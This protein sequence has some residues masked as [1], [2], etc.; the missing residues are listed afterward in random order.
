[1]RSRIFS[2]AIFTLAAA[3]GIA[4]TP[5]IVSAVWPVSGRAV[6]DDPAAQQ[7]P[8]ITGDGAG[9][10]I[11]VWE[12]ARTPPSLIAAQHVLATERSIPPGLISAGC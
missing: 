8:A 5:R 7:H 1:M 4:A 3:F 6:C 2:P 11:V 10:A 12:D 9:G